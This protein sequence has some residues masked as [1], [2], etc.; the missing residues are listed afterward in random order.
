M[1]MQIACFEKDVAG[2]GRFTL[3]TLQMPED[4]PLVHRWVTHERARY[5]GLQNRSPDEVAEAYRNI[6]AQPGSSVFL[7]FHGDAPAFLLECYHPME[8][9]VGRCYDAR[10]GDRGMHILVAPS[11]RPI[12]Q[13]TWHVFTVVMDFLFSDDAVER[14]VVEP[15]VRNENIH[16]LNRRAGFEYQ[17]IIQLPKK[18]AYLALCTRAQYVTACTQ[19]GLVPEQTP[20]LGVTVD[21]AHLT[22]GVWSMVNALH[23]QKIIREFTHER[24]LEPRIED[25]EHGWGRYVLSTDDPDIEYR[26]RA[27]L[28]NLEHWHIDPASIEKHVR[29]GRAPLDAVSLILEVRQRIGIEAATLPLYMEEILSTLCGNAYKHAYQRFD[30]AELA[31]AEF[32]EVERG[33]TEGHPVFVANSGRIGFDVQDYRN[34]APEAGADIRLVWLAVHRSRATFACVSDLTYQDLLEGELGSLA[35]DAFNRA[36]RKEGLN[37]ETYL[38]MPAHPWQW[39]NKLAGLFAPDLA[40]RKLVYLG[41]GDDR[42]RAQQSIRTFFNLTHPERFYV[43]T[44]LS[45]LNMGFMRGLSSYYMS[46]TPAINEYLHGLIEGDAY[47]RGIGFTILREVASIGYRHPHFEMAV[48]GDSPYKKMLAALWRESPVPR[49]AAGERLMTM[50][51]LLHRDRDGSALLPALIQSSGLST[52]EWLRRYLRCYLAPLLHCFYVHDL[53]FMPHGENLI[54]VLRDHAPVRVF[55][56][57][58]AEEAALLDGRRELPDSIRRLAVCVPE[59]LKVLSLFIDVFDCFF[60][61]LAEIC[62]E[63]GLC[64]E[65]AFWR[66]VA[67]CVLE[68]QRSH[69]ELSEKFQRHDLFAPEFRRSCLNRLQL[70]NNRQMIDLA[71]PAKNLKFVGVLKNPLATFRRGASMTG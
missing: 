18:T 9:A 11:D 50:A 29:G 7:G 64:S 52:E 39:E 68:Y 49:L 66:L 27:Q 43:K 10:P 38:F 33:M 51:A 34:Y 55:L 70:A 45:I 46:T 37:P 36:L 4:L 40:S 20:V 17:D 3:R 67:D 31:Q 5:W 35:V 12:A 19:S 2:V 25:T 47:L 14:I 32:Q 28:L 63:Q 71:D 57:D 61:H 60:R 53:V 23:V 24:L 41:Q 8:D 54:L 15:D 65:T 69:P 42:Y 26:F 16:R 30:A 56:K 48:T 1:N 21:M 22:P 13:F 6:L 62:W 58:I 59:E 44:A